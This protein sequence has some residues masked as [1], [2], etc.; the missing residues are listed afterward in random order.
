MSSLHISESST[1]DHFWKHSGPMDPPGDISS[2]LLNLPPESFDMILEL[3]PPPAQVCLLLTCRGLYNVYKA[4]ICDVG[5]QFTFDQQR[6]VR[7]VI[8][9]ID[10]PT[11]Y[12]KALLR[13][14]QNDRWAYCSECFMLHPRT[15]FD[16]SSQVP[17]PHD[18]IYC[19][20]CM[21][22]HSRDPF[23]GTLSG[24][25]PPHSAI[26]TAQSGIVDLC[27]CI[28]LNNRQKFRIVRYLAGGPAQ[29]YDHQYPAIKDDRRFTVVEKGSK[30]RVLVHECPMPFYGDEA[31]TAQVTISLD[32]ER[33]SVVAR[34]KYHLCHRKLPPVRSPYDACPHRCLLRLSCYPKPLEFCLRCRTKFRLHNWESWA[35][36]Q[37]FNVTRDLGG[38]RWPPDAVWRAQCRIRDLKWYMKFWEED[39]IVGDWVEDLNDSEDSENSESSGDSDGWSDSSSSSGSRDGSDSDDLDASEDS[40]SAEDSEDLDNG[41]I[42]SESDESQDSINE[43]NSAHLEAP[44]DSDDDG[45][46]TI[47]WL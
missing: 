36:N 13:L 21:R 10:R 25:S 39:P 17:S 31:F 11:I 20:E 40:A 5:A 41:E 45:G 9:R 14:L 46:I 6:P 28:T 24:P 38:L 27:S 7:D 33:K 8:Y 32:R 42:S 30:T 34:T 19:L 3:L 2:G 12:R 26:C 18:W 4:T 35:P 16:G 1:P 47:D 37:W 43:E 15:E 29:P 23:H 44:D 22:L